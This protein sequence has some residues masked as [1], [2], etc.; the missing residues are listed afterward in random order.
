M[1]N[2]IIMLL[3][4]K[5]PWG[6]PQ[7]G[8]QEGF[9][10]RYARCYVNESTIPQQTISESIAYCI[11]I[12]MSG[13]RPYNP[14]VRVGNWCEDL[15]LEEVICYYGCNMLSLMVNDNIRPFI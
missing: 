10:P 11:Q 1:K 3:S 4:R 7:S 12:K 9:L 13:V 14:S 6:W 5:A 2:D 8:C 15:S